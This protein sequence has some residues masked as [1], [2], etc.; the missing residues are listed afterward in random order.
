MVH[1]LGDYEVGWILARSCVVE[2]AGYKN[3]QAIRE[4]AC[5]VL[6]RALAFGVRSAWPEWVIF[7]DRLTF[8]GRR[9]DRRAARNND[10]CWWFSKRGCGTEQIR[11]TLDINCVSV[12]ICL[13]SRGDGG[14][15]NDDGRIYFSDSAINP[16]SVQQ[17]TL[18]FV[19]CRGP[20]GYPE[21]L[22][23]VLPEP[24]GERP[25]GKAARTGQQDPLR[26]RRQPCF[27]GCRLQ[28]SSRK[29]RQVTCV[30]PTRA[31][32]LR[33]RHRRSGDQPRRAG[34]TPGSP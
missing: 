25:S 6:H 10:A 24:C 8:F 18:S 23:S 27:S 11:C 4:C 12:A 30:P 21:D 31:W 3:P 20:L 15:M 17:V 34:N 32:F 2:R 5:N 7:R 13:L 16:I 28:P 26:M 22:V 9:I 1:D 33:G 14:E 29:D 19:V